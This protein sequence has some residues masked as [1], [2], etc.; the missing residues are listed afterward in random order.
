MVHTCNFT[1]ACVS[2]DCS[3]VLLIRF[4]AQQ[5]CDLASIFKFQESSA[6][7]TR[8]NTYQHI[9]IKY[10]ELKICTPLIYIYKAWYFI[11]GIGILRYLYLKELHIEYSMASGGSVGAY[12]G[13]TL[14]VVTYVSTRHVPHRQILQKS[15]YIE[16]RHWRKLSVN[17]VVTSW[18]LL[19][20]AKFCKEGTTGIA[21]PS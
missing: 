12:G 2:M 5:C 20:D 8:L 3:A 11:H 17:S 10:W 9:S 1:R 13:R 7:Q 4:A 15:I 18:I 16:S 14:V 21:I 19:T 6:L